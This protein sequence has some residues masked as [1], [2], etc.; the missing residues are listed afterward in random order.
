[1]AGSLVTLRSSALKVTVSIGAVKLVIP[2]EA[3]TSRPSPRFA[4]IRNDRG[5]FAPSPSLLDSLDAIAPVATFHVVLVEVGDHRIEVV[6]ELRNIFG[7]GLMEAKDLVNDTPSIVKESV[8]RAEAE[9]IKAALESV[10][11]T[12]ALQPL[13]WRGNGQGNGQ[14]APQEAG[15][16]A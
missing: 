11:A 3:M 16:G 6:K 5:R 10:G 7:L 12:A 4:R 2:I 1:L 9:A 13:R 14:Y 15:H 8:S